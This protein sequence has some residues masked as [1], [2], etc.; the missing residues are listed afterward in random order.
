MAGVLSDE[1]F[2][3]AVHLLSELSNSLAVWLLKHLSFDFPT[4]PLD[5]FSVIFFSRIDVSQMLP[6]P[7]PETAK[8][9][10]LKQRFPFCLSVSNTSC[11]C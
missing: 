1:P 6:L 8:Q 3:L 7:T 5:A 4:L 11:Q 10:N 2:C 9:Q